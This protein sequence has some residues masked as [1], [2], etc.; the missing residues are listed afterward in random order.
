MCVFAFI[1]L[2]FYRVTF[3]LSR[4]PEL[5]APSWAKRKLE[6]DLRPCNQRK[7]SMC[8]CSW[9]AFCCLDLCKSYWRKWRDTALPLT[10]KELKASNV[11][12]E[13]ERYKAYIPWAS[14]CTVFLTLQYITLCITLPTSTFLDLSSESFWLSINKQKEW[15][16]LLWITIATSNPFFTSDIVFEDKMMNSR[17]TVSWIPNIPVNFLLYSVRIT[18]ILCILLCYIKEPQ[19]IF[20]LYFLVCA[21]SSCVSSSVKFCL[22][23]RLNSQPYKEEVTSHYF[24]FLFFKSGHSMHFSCVI[25]GNWALNGIWVVF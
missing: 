4:N 18:H 10:L 20:T 22:F 17:I 21:S 12:K 13:L 8:S 23:L 3:C 16:R 1:C 15:E 14:K 11:N 9:L 2:Y 25:L 6:L 24:P 7:E 19:C 5:T